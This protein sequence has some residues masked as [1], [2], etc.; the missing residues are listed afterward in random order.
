MI[1]IKNKT[2]SPVQLQIRS[3]Q[4]PRA[5]TPLTIPGI[6]AGKNV[7]AIEEERIISDFLERAVKSGMLS[8]RYIANKKV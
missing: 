6:G 2:Q 5:F 8:T 1:E 4:G 3:R 7:V